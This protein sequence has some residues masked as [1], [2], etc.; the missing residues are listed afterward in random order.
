MCTAIS[1]R[2]EFHYFGRNL[3]VENFFDERVTITPRNYPFYFYGGKTLYSHYAMIGMAHIAEGYPL[4]YDAV[5]EKGLSVAA[6]SFPKEAY[7]GEVRDG[8]YP[9]TPWEW[10]PFILSECETAEQAKRLLENTE[11]V[12]VPFSR[13]L[14]LTPLHFLVSDAEKSFTAEPMKDGLRIFENP[15][16]V[17][18]NAPSFD[19]QMQYLN[20]F[21]GLSSEP[22]ENRFSAEIPFCDYSRGMG[23]LGLPGDLSSSSRFVRTVFTKFHTLKGSDETEDVHRFFHIL[24][25]AEQQ[26]GCVHLDGKYEFT[27]YSSCCNTDRGIYYYKTYENSSIIGI[28]MHR[29]NL[30]GEKLISYSLVKKGDLKSRIGN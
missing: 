7:Y 25:I 11:I 19:F 3:D 27:A 12:R 9:I 24:G 26:M 17:L 6:L 4:Y 2:S 13:E 14:P 29:E 18:T 21:M 30:N 28:D 5:N 22:I 16:G 1:Y 15:V 10:I 20:L 8:C 23:A